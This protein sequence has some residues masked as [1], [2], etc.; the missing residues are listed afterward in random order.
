MIIDDVEPL[1]PFGA[2]VH[3]ADL[4][5][6]DLERDASLLVDLLDRHRVLLFRKQDIEPDDQVR[7]SAAFGTPLSE[8]EALGETTGQ[9]FTQ[10]ENSADGVS[11]KS[12]TRLPF[13]SD[14]AFSPAPYATICL[15]ALEVSGPMPTMYANAVT[16]CATLSPELRDRIAS[17][18][19]V[20]A[21]AVG[22]TDSFRV[23]IQDLP[24]DTDL[25]MYPHGSYPM[26]DVHP[27]TGEEFL[28]TCEMQSSYV[29]GLPEEASE[30][31]LAAL[32]AHQYQ[33]QHTTSHTWEP[34]DVVV[35]DNVA[36]QHGRAAFGRA[37][38][39]TLRRVVTGSPQ[40]IQYLRGA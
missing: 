33:P 31:L 19:V 38:R 4:R 12:H 25:T 16:A 18:R 3:A 21:Y 10:V 32:F 37:A 17:R 15:Y 5:D 34:G 23:R 28:R 40:A 9:L 39:R 24:P 27:R 11:I 29:E 14:M 35:W 2:A 36:L 6:L 20:N 26:I 1:E 30:E 7:L 8:T 13:H 22:S